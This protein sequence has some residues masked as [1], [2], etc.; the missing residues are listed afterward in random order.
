MKQ[1]RLLDWITYI[2]IVGTHITLVS[3][4]RYVGFCLEAAQQLA[5]QGIECEVFISRNIHIAVLYYDTSVSLNGK[6]KTTVMLFWWAAYTI[7]LPGAGDSFVTRI[8]LGSD[9]VVFKS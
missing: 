8:L 1:G 6:V 7:V 9:W 4:S 5:G 2:S 3:H